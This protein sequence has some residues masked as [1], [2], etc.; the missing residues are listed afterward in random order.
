[1]RKKKSI[2]SSSGFSLIELALAM[3]II[4]V[5]LISSAAF[6]DNMM[7]AQRYRDSLVEMQ[8]LGDT[9]YGKP[10]FLQTGHQAS[11]GY[12]GVNRDYPKPAA[13]SLGYLYAFIQEPKGT[14]ALTFHDLTQDE[15]GYA[16]TWGYSGGVYTI[17]SSGPDGPTGGAG[18][19]VTYEV[20]DSMYRYNNVRIYIT[21]ARGTPLRSS[22]FGENFF[23][24]SYS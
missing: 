14:A 17:T 12:W 23:F 20:N 7:R 6:V 10:Y 13:N 9:V 18:D 3:L 8:K 5:I 19:D 1:M 16:Y 15:F 24:A 4:S 2:H 11:F 22:H 21:D